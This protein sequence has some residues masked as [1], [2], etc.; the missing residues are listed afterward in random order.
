MAAPS[1]F[2]LCNVCLPLSVTNSGLHLHIHMHIYTHSK[3]SPNHCNGS[4]IFWALSLENPS[5][6]DSCLF[7]TS[8]AENRGCHRICLFLILTLPPE[9]PSCH[10][11]SWL[12]WT[13]TLLLEDPSWHSS[14]LFLFLHYPRKIPV[15]MVPVYSLLYPGGSQLPQFLSGLD[16]YSTYVVSQLLEFLSII[17]SHFTPGVPQLPKF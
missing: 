11:F 12:F 4:C 6:Q 7:W 15:A 10:T 3:T 9:Y 16:F 17:D 8:T 14:C 2:Y 5:H 1:L 13:P